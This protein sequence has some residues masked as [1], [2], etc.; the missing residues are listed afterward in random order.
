[1]NLARCLSST[2]WVEDEAFTRVIAH[3]IAVMRERP[4]KPVDID[5]PSFPPPVLARARAILNETIAMSFQCQFQQVASIDPARVARDA[6]AALRYFDLMDS[7]QR[8]GFKYET[9]SP[10][11]RAQLEA[12]VKTHKEEG[13][14][15]GYKGRNHWEAR[16]FPEVLGLFWAL[17][18]EEPAATMNRDTGRSQS[19]ALVFIK[20]VLC[21]V[22]ASDAAGDL[23]IA[24]RFAGLE[25]DDWTVHS[26][27]ALRNKVSKWK[28]QPAAAPKKPS[29]WIENGLSFKAYL[30]SWGRTKH[31]VSPSVD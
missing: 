23:Y 4:R 9:A 21:E 29:E 8:I 7:L 5:L 31:G 1:M 17:F 12:T 16:F 18:Q 11:L 27:E 3:T 10:S 14:R 20:Q 30:G 25:F 22:H 15:T 19:A 26:D 2:E 24:S 28:K 6:E 13:S